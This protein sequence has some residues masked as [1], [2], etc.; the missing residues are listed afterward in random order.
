MKTADLKAAVDGRTPVAVRFKPPLVGRNIA[1]ARQ[2][3]ADEAP[4][5]EMLKPGGLGSESIVPFAFRRAQKPEA[6][7][8]IIV[9][10]VGQRH[11]PEIDLARPGVASIHWRTSQTRIKGKG[12]GQHQTAPFWSKTL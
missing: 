9:P 3:G 7:S 1:V 11:I 5:G 6:R 10:E 12:F 8:L 4:C 2:G